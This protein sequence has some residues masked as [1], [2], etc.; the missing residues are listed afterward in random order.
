MLVLFHCDL[1]I[2][3]T[4]VWWR[5]AFEVEGQSSPRRGIFE[6]PDMVS[7]FQAVTPEGMITRAGQHI[8]GAVAHSLAPWASGCE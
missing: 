7:R 6:E 1:L 4:K 8:V 2:S 3:T 5:S